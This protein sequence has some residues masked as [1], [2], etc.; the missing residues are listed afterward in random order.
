MLTPPLP[1]SGLRPSRLQRRQPSGS[2]A[3][4]RFKPVESSS[5]QRSQETH[6]HDHDGQYNSRSLQYQS[7]ADVRDESSLTQ[8]SSN[9][10]RQEQG[11]G[12]GSSSPSNISASMSR[13]P[14]TTNKARPIRVTSKIRVPIRNNIGV[15]HRQEDHV[16]GEPQGQVDDSATV[17]LM[18]HMQD[19]SD[20]LQTDVDAD[21]QRSPV[22]RASNSRNA[23]TS[24]PPFTDSVDHGQ[25]TSRAADRSIP[26]DKAPLNAVP[27]NFIQSQPQQE[28]ATELDT[29]AQNKDDGCR[30]RAR[31]SLDDPLTTDSIQDDQLATENDHRHSSKQKRRPK[32]D[33]QLSGPE[34]MF[35]LVNPH[36]DNKDVVSR[37]SKDPK[38]AMTTT[39]RQIDTRPNMNSLLSR[40][41]RISDQKA[42]EYKR[43][44]ESELGFSQPMYSD[45]K[46][47]EV[48]HQEERST[49]DQ[50]Y[51]DGED[52]KDDATNESRSASSRSSSLRMSN[53]PALHQDPISGRSSPHR[54]L[55]PTPSSPSVSITKGDQ[56]TS[57]LANEMPSKKHHNR[58]LPGLGSSFAPT[59]SPVPT[60]ELDRRRPNNTQEPQSAYMDVVASNEWLSKWETQLDQQTRRIQENNK[61]LQLLA[62]QASEQY[63]DGNHSEDC[64]EEIQQRLFWAEEDRYELEEALFLLGQAQLL[65]QKT[66]DDLELEQEINRDKDTQLQ[67]ISAQLREQ[68]E[69]GEIQ[70]EELERI[71]QQSTMDHELWEKRV[72]VEKEERQGQLA[73]K[74]RELAELKTQRETAD[75]AEVASLHRIIEELKAQINDQEKESRAN[76]VAQVEEIRECHIQIRGMDL[77]LQHEQD[78]QADEQELRSREKARI[79][80]LKQ[81]VKQ[82][83]DKMDELQEELEDRESSLEQCEEELLDTRATVDSI[84]PQ[85][86]QQQKRIET[87]LRSQKESNQA[88]ES[89]IQQLQDELD[90]R[91]RELT[92][93]SSSSTSI[94]TTVREQA[95]TIKALQAQIQEHK[96]ALVKMKTQNRKLEEE[97]EQQR[98]KAQNEISYLIQDVDELRRENDEKVTDLLKE[99]ANAKD[100]EAQLNQGVQKHQDELDHY[101]EREQMRLERLLAELEST[102]EFDGPNRE[103]YGKLGD[104][105]VD[106][107]MNN[108]N[109]AVGQTFVRLQGTIRKLKEEYL[110]LDDEQRYH[111][112]ELYKYDQEINNQRECIQ[113]MEQDRKSLEE[114]RNRLQEDLVAVQDEEQEMR[115]QLERKD[116]EL[117]EEI[118]RSAEGRDHLNRTITLQSRIQLLEGRISILKQEKHQLKNQLASAQGTIQGL[119]E[120]MQHQTEAWESKLVKGKVRIAELEEIVKEYYLVLDLAKLEQK[121]L[122]GRKEVVGD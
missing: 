21:V 1:A 104:S 92:R 70:A 58:V 37:T 60:M 23:L 122:K 38:T 31:V 32:E 91:T 3:Q 40:A 106:I 6:H 54:N 73:K 111:E 68:I 35:Q 8:G 88:H 93:S 49:D 87:L 29:D 33:R 2:T 7:S 39:K 115:E 30:D 4:R 110:D 56:S 26:E 47:V 97:L 95:E 77:E 80:K 90:R 10:D 43:V 114:Q 19:A 41:R 25:D 59:P 12:Q 71:H 44:I 108:D 112:Q 98:Q 121:R 13:I 100:M 79:D 17:K 74:D 103:S 50:Q 66:K 78:R 83:A 118:K 36:P 48:S 61:M 55:D 101:Q 52:V 119:E 82:M 99:R 85:L 20:S 57:S 107:D 76:L 94:E 113:R 86:L 75:Q 24:P 64:G 81:T 69:L 116:E 89:T 14:R 102:E 65:H 5:S 51:M 96:D 62:I 11:Q 18:S 45:S 84:K 105:S 109:T 16:V 53:L 120:M 67:A 46:N 42:L 9:H 15:Y 34:G 117:R 27:V 72:S 63:E 28:D 22:S